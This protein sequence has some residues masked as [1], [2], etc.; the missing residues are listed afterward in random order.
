MLDA[1]HTSRSSPRAFPEGRRRRA[2]RF[3]IA[4]CSLG[5]VLVATTRRGVCAIEIG[6]DR[7]PLARDFEDRMPG[8]ER[9][10]GDRELDAVAAF[11][12]A[13]IEAP[14]HGFSLPLDVR[15]TAFQKRVWL[16]LTGIPVGATATY[17]EIAGRIG[18]PKAVRAVA[19]ACAANS[20]A[21]AI[22]CHRV[23]RTDGSPGGYRWG[24]A[25]KE[26]LLARERAA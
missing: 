22:P 9:F 23:V 13:Q 6:D 2:V 5:A 3:T 24:V 26:A 20:V 25:R 4:D 10:G 11:V 16:A 7:G 18:A 8:A 21:I 17:A 19:Q 14:S 15:G 12:V 1:T